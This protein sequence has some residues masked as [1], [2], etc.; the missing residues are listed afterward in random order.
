MGIA[1]ENDIE[2]L[3]QDT[4][5]MHIPKK[6]IKSLE[7]I[8]KAKFGRSLRGENLGEFHNDLESKF[9]GDI[10][11]NCVSEECII[12]G[13]KAYLDVLVIDFECE[14]N[15]KIIKNNQL[16]M[17]E[18]KTKKEYHIRLKGVG[19]FAFKRNFKDVEGAYKDLYNNKTLEFDLTKG[20][21]KFQISNMNNIIQKDNFK[22]NVSFITV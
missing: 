9:D 3:Y 2:V 17:E 1:N 18:L 4:D 13:K 11:F 21:V 10:M 20:S 7:T 15:K 12:L 8:F 6:H 19:S 16:D 22:R 5:S 14:K